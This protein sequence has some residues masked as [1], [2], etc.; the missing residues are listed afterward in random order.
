MP[1]GSRGWIE[2]ERTRDALVERLV[3]WRERGRPE[4]IPATPPEIEAALG[5]F[6]TPYGDAA[7]DFLAAQPQAPIVIL[8]RV[9]SL[10]HESLERRF[11]REDRTDPGEHPPL[12]FLRDS[13]LVFFR[14]LGPKAEAVAPDLLELLRRR[15]AEG[16]FIDVTGRFF[17][18]VL[19]AVPSPCP[20]REARSGGTAGVRWYHLIY[21]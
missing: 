5:L 17:R 2:R 13:C 10:F 14:T 16:E 11:T 4:P 15:E 9:E 20:D 18:N 7:A 3:A 19:F 12:Q 1:G 21:V 6:P 8:P